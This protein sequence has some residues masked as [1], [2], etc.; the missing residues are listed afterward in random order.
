MLCLSGRGPTSIF[1]EDFESLTGEIW[2]EFSSFTNGDFNP[3]IGISPFRLGW[4]KTGISH[5]TYSNLFYD[6]YTN[7]KYRLSVCVST[8]WLTSQV[9]SHPKSS[10]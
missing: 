4:M 6:M 2:I 8:F 5:H 3:L 7:S 10:I 9:L 1:R